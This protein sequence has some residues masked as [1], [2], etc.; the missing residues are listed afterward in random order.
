M[1][2]LRRLSN[3][4]HHARA[5]RDIDRELAFHIG[6]RIDQLRAEGLSPDEARLVAHRQF[7]SRRRVREEAY[8]MNSTGRLERLGQDV[9]ITLRMLRKSP[10]FTLAAILTLALGIGAT[11]AV[12]SVVNG[13]LLRPLPYPQPD[14]LI[15]IWHSAQFQGVTSNNVRLSSTM[16]LTYREHNRTFAEFGLWRTTQASVIGRGDPEQVPAL[17]V[18]YGTLPAVGVPPAIG[19]WFSEADDTPATPETAILTYGYWQRRFAGS[20]TV[21]G[22]AVTIDGRPRQVIG[23]M[24]ERFRFLNADAAVILPQRFEGQ[25]LLPNDVH[26]YLGIARLKPGVSLAQANADVT[27]MLPIWIAERGTNANV[28]TAARFGAAVRPVKEDVVGDVGQVLWLMM[29][30]IGIVLVIACANVANLLLVRAEGRRHELA[31]RAALGAGWRHIARQLLVESLVLAVLGGALAVGLAYAGVRLLVSIGPATLPRLSEISIDPSVLTFAIVASLISAALFGLL[32]VVRYAGTRGTGA[33]QSAAARGDRRTASP[34]RG[35]HR[36]QSALV[37]V[38]VALAVVLLVAS[39][40]LMRSFQAL[41]DVD[42]GFDRPDQIQTLRISIPPGQVEDA[43]RVTRMQ[44]DML[45]AISSLPGVRSAS[46]ATALPMEMEYENN[47]VVTAS[48]KTYAEGIPPLRRTKAVAPGFFETL[49][50]PLLAG[51]SFTWTDVN[52]RRAVAVVSNNLARELWGDPLSALG[53]QIR[54]GRGGPLNEVVG[55]VGDVYDS[56]VDR[57]APA[58]VYWRAGVQKVAG[59]I[60]AFTPRELTFA[61]LSDRAGTEEFIKQIGRAVWSVNP[62]LPMARVQTLSEIYAASMSRTSFTLVMLAIAGAM[63]LMLGIVG[64]YGVISYAVTEQRRAIGIRLAL[65]AARAAILRRFLGQGL[66]IA[67]AACLS[68]IALSLVV[69]GTL[70]RVL[71]GVSPFDP[72]TLVSVIG[73]ILI[74]ATLAALIPAT[75]AAFMEPMRTLREE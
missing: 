12:F 25:Q 72:V 27:R 10:G 31:V 62:S 42:P 57:P 24:P 43:E 68:G 50:I 39:G 59:P 71:Y 55:V 45:T 8:E 36:S 73:I 46:F 41:R 74:V 67:G 56:G 15:G 16:Y 32:P 52:D 14:A 22:T 58:I 66:R 26:M 2:W 19:R 23:V 60:P 21:I 75:R 11:T 7:G 28:L 1:S 18:T 33:L 54:I 35:Q 5:Q 3:T 53:K 63:A 65:G 48:D 51:R 13:V 37:F 30:T 38:Q 47:T 40:L 17:I 9:R 34:S 69:G 6:E 70:S 44:E 29:G 64:I 61:I 4:L 20:A 49:G